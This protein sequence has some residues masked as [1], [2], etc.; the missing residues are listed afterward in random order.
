MVTEQDTDS[1]ETVRGFYEARGAAS[2]ARLETLTAKSLRLSGGRLAVFVGGI[3]VAPVYAWGDFLSFGAALAVGL[4]FLAA[5]VV[6]VI[7]HRRVQAGI[8]R[9]TREVTLCEEGVARIARDWGALRAIPSPPVTDGFGIGAD[10]D[11]F[12]AGSLYRLTGGAVTRFGQDT[13]ARWLLSPS[14]PAKSA[15]RGRLIGELRGNRAALMSFQHL[16][17][18]MEK[19]LL[20]P[21][22]FVAWTK[23]RGWLEAHRGVLWGARILTPLPILLGLLS[24][25]NLLPGPFWMIA[26]VVNIA[27]S[28]IHTP[29]IHRVF[30]AV[31]RHKG[32]ID[33][34]ASLFRFMAEWEVRAERGRDLK[35]RLETDGVT[36]WRQMQRLETLAGFADLRF[37]PMTH[38]PIQAFTLID[39]HVLARMER[40]QRRA[41]AHTEGWLEALG[42]FEAFMALALL[43][44]D[45][46]D[47][48][49]A[50]IREGAPTFEARGLGHPLL[51]AET[52]VA[53]DVTLGP[54]G[55]FLLVTGSNMSGKSSLLRSIGLNVALAGAGGPVAAKSL[56]LTPFTLG[57]SFR[58][59]DS[60]SDGISF[61]MAELKRLKQ[62]VTRAEAVTAGDPPLLFLLD[63][64]LQGTN[65]I[66]RRVAVAG[67]LKHLVG[68]DCLGAISSHDLTLAEAEEI[69]DKAVPVYFT[70]RFRD[71]EKGREMYFD[72][73]LRPGVAPTTNALE[74]LKLVGLDY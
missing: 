71:G 67:V 58:V 46:P 43:A 10:L 22:P 74:L 39:F 40:W 13:L 30:A 28:A 36:A 8:D 48:A 73:T 12:G 34:Y 55:T 29:K 1:P 38:F 7:A 35:A 54:P 41:G 21:A 65:I 19:A 24:A 68:L 66:E 62:I 53:N 72:F 27:F 4:S 15:A 42:E 26:V 33:Q 70:E 64:I 5:F 11:L 17:L 51:P 44:H 20:D 50:E 31:S 57:T 59:T 14:P 6:L 37:S 61:F 25:F 56:T 63:E 32:R 45:N 3:A 16:T 47:W 52:L 69:G 49:I 60:I 23:G 9:E 18:A 2:R